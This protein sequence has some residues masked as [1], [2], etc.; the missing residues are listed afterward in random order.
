MLVTF[1]SFWRKAKYCEQSLTCQLYKVI[2]ILSISTLKQSRFFWQL[3]VF[4]LFV[5][6]WIKKRFTNSEWNVKR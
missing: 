5:E 1:L 6:L 2:N 4:E 3:L